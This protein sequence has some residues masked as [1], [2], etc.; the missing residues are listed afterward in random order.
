LSA[1]REELER[2]WAVPAGWIGKLR[3]VHN[4]FTGLVFLGST[5][6][7]FTLSGFDSLAIRAQLALPE[8]DLIGAAKF[9]QLFTTHGTAMMFLFAIPMLEALAIYVLPLMLGTRDMAFPRM[10]ALTIW[11]FI[12][13]GLLFYAST[14]PDIASFVLPGDL[15]APVPDA[16]WFAYPPLTDR[17]YSPGLNI[18]FYLLGLGFAEFAGIAAAIELIVTI[19]KMRAPGLSL[20]RMPLFAWSI[21]VVAFAILI[22]FPAV[23]VGTTFLELQRKFGLPFFDPARGGDPLLWQHLFWIFGHPEVY[24]MFIPATGIVSMI[25]PAF[26]GRRIAGYLF[27]ATAIAATGFMSF[28]LWVH[29]MFTTGL[30]LFVVGLFGAASMVIAIPSGVQVFAWLATMVNAPRLRLAT[31]M[32]Y[33]FGF[34]ITFVVGG[35]TGVMVASVPFDWQAHDTYFV[36][37]HFHYVMVGGVVFPILAGLVY[38]WPKMSGRLM[39]ERIG[40]WAFWIIFIGFNVCFLPQH[41]AGL[42]GMPRRVYT[43]DADLGLT[44]YNLASSIGAFVMAAGFL[45]F[46]ANI[47][48]SV[49]RGAKAPPDP[50]RTAGLEWSVPSPPPP[51]NFRE[52]PL[53]RGRDPLRDG[54]HEPWAPSRRRG[55]TAGRLWL[56]TLVTTTFESRPHA[57]V[58]LAGSSYVPFALATTLTLASAALLFEIYPVAVATGVVSIPLVFR[59]LWPSREERALV[60]AGRTLGDADLPAHTTGTASTGWW[61]MV[62]TIVALAATLVLLVYSHLYLVYAGPSP[63]E[64][65]RP[66]LAL[67]VA[68][69][70]VLLASAVP[71]ILALRA[72]R[73]GDLSAVR[74][75]LGLGLVLGAAYVLVATL[76]LL[77]Q[78]LAPVA[79]A[80]DAM[81]ATVA[82]Y[83]IALAVVGAAAIAFVLVQAWLGHFGRSRHGAVENV[84]LLWSFVVVSGVAIVATLHLSPYLL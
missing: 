61:G 73:R 13:G 70:A 21:L 20:D 75:G 55:A 57:I 65:H 71:P 35:L 69:V 6:V 42:L 29:H 37:A 72:V 54:A 40:K 19:L 80:Y 82:G 17:T 33:V 14:L 41:S 81:F 30:A 84:V 2:L 28:G 56:E 53:V 50:W 22:A 18:D 63:D 24:I 64:V 26:T 34:I 67:A 79:R 51:Y 76:D 62:L 11:S 43:Y 77:G 5:F 74:S 83:Q 7:F 15:E 59:W 60:G 23:L 48:R 3:T 32:L 38:W 66:H 9:N 36:V 45:L 46:G 47:L 52:I 68:G 4:G 58:V 8:L 12:M 39:D 44:A 78:G 25:V 16:G 10:S 31:P 27:V 1:S 49:L